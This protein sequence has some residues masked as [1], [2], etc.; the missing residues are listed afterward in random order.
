MFKIRISNNNFYNDVV[1]GK[2]DYPELHLEINND[3]TDGSWGIKQEIN[4]EQF[5]ISIPKIKMAFPELISDSLIGVQP[6]GGTLSLKER[7]F[8]TY[9][10]HVIRSGPI[11]KRKN[12]NTNRKKTFRY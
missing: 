9:E 12:E 1:T 11:Y 3:R 5:L 4:F 6:I 8:K 10:G 2:E 7:M